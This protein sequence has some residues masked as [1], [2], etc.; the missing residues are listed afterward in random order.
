MAKQQRQQGGQEKADAGDAATKRQHVVISVRDHHPDAR[1]QA[2]GARKKASAQPLIARTV[3]DRAG[4][5]QLTER[6]SEIP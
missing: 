3:F 5:D 2:S 1:T 6:G 4:A